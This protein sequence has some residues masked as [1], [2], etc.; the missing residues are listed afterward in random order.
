MW[1]GR[2]GF[3][4][5]GR[6]TP[7]DL[8]LLLLAALAAIGLVR[9]RPDTAPLPPA[10]IAGRPAPDVTL[11]RLDGAP[12]RRADLRGS[13]VVLNCSASF[14]APCRDE[15]PLLHEYADRAAATGERT[16]IVGVGVRT[17]ID[18]DARA[19]VRELGVTYPIGRDTATEAPGDG[20]I[21]QAFGPLAFLPST[22]F[23]RPDGIVDRLHVGELDAEQLRAAVGE[24]RAASGP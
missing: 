9:R 20:P 19:L 3:G 14:C 24:A 12:L 23:I 18:A 21:Q 13:V 5:Y 15:M 11:T 2:I 8:A 22:V 16:A 6:F 17:D 10:P 4:R 7:L 1:L